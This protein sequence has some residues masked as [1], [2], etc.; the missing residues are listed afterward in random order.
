MI[1]SGRVRPGNIGVLAYPNKVKRAVAA[2]LRERAVV[3]QEHADES[4]I[5]LGDP[6]V[7]VLPM[8]SSKGLEFPV[9]FVVA[10]GRHF[11]SPRG[12]D[13]MRRLF[14]VAMTRAMSELVFVY[15]AEDP[16]PFVSPA[17]P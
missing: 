5:R 3:C 7:K 16:P 8:K 4:A 15:D 14:Y 13:E 12:T 6:S 17:R 2:R 9:V 10:S 11:Q 1:E